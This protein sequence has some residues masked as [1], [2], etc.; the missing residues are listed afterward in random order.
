MVYIFF[1]QMVCHHWYEIHFT[2]VLI[3]MVHR[4]GICPLECLAYPEHALCA[5][6]IEVGVASMASGHGLAPPNDE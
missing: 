5:S 1:V 3:I 4:F 2:V 6:L